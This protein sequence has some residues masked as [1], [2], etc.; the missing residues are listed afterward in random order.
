[1]LRHTAIREANKRLKKEAEDKG[2]EFREILVPARAQSRDPD[3]VSAMKI[4]AE[5]AL[6][7]ELTIM[8]K[9]EHAHRLATV[10][11]VAHLDIAR[12]MGVSPKTIDTHRT[13]LMSKLD[14]HDAQSVT[15]YAI[16]RGL[17]SKE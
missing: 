14:L 16:R 17:V 7:E 5:N 1:M 4:G 8:Q 12:S 3:K 9:A 15:R 13:N 2:E 6:R 11:E 10:F